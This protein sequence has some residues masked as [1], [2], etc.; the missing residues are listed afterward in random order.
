M[1]FPEQAVEDLTVE[2]VTMQQ[3]HEME[4]KSLRQKLEEDVKDVTRVFEGK[5]AAA[6]RQYGE[7]R[8]RERKAAAE[9][10]VQTKQVSRLF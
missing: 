5:M 4:V 2:K 9:V 3:R 8:D 7:E 10:L 6:D 1:L